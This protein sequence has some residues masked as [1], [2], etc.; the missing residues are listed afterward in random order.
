MENFEAILKYQEIDIKLRKALDTI[1]KS[2]VYEKMEKARQ[3]FSA[4]KKVRDDNEKSAE[5]I[6]NNIE[7]A[8]KMSDEICEMVS[9][10]ANSDDVCQEDIT[11][12]EKAK[13]KLAEIES[14]LSDKKTQS[15]KIIKEFLEANEQLKKLKAVFEEYKKEYLA[16][17]EKKQPEINALNEQLKK[18]EPQISETILK[19]Y[20]AVTAEKKY[21]AFVDA[22]IDKDSYYCRGCGIALS[23]SATS[24]LKNQSYCVCEK[25]K[26]V[27]YKQ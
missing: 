24:E 19:K 13:A 16:L 10:M 20:K 17:K 5:E 26:R 15:E 11:Q 25:C 22:Y 3:N 8:Q 7:R 12:L 18:L 14:M 1:E 21:P 4:A 27:I 9:R 23:Q 2:D 6:L